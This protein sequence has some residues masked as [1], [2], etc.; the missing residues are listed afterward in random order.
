[1]LLPLLWFIPW[2]YLVIRSIKKH[3]Q[4]STIFSIVYGVLGFIFLLYF[5]KNEWPQFYFNIVTL[6]GIAG[7]A[8]TN[9]K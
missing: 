6:V 3:Y 1:M 9:K 2:T 4:L 5:K 7:I 8:L